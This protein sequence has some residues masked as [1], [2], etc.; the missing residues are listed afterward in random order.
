MNWTDTTKSTQTSKTTFESESIFRPTKCKEKD[1]PSAREDRH[2]DTQIRRRTDRQ[3]DRQTD[4]ETDRRG[5]R[6][7]ER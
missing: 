4:R 1:N 6:Y 2:T 5:E 7:R 3:T